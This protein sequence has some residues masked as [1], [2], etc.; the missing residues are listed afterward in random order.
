MIL[1][2]VY[3]HI[4]VKEHLIT[5]LTWRGSTFSSIF[6]FSRIS[7]YKSSATSS[8]TLILVCVSHS[9]AALS[10]GNS[11]RKRRL[12]SLFSHTS[13]TDSLVLQCKE[14]SSRQALLDK[15]H[16]IIVVMFLSCFRTN[17]FVKELFLMKDITLPFFAI[18]VSG[19]LIDR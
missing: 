17:I 15:C 19:K 10:S 3:A 14:N 11:S 2:R 7:R 5:V 1:W 12:F 9:H 8:Q 4:P 13:R 6:F 18:Q 16:F